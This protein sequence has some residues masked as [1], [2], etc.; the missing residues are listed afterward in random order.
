MVAAS[1]EKPTSEGS[2]SLA[3]GGLYNVLNFQPE[4]TVWLLNISDEVRNFTCW[5]R[6]LMAI[7]R[8]PLAHRAADGGYYGLCV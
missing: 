3:S 4:N 1:P 6:N 5:C 8:R 7:E 2:T